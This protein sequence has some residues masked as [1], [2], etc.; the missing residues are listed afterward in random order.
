[1]RTQTFSGGKVFHLARIDDEAV[2]NF[3]VSKIFGDLRGVVHGAAEE[4]DFASVLVGELDSEINAVDRRREA[5]DKKAALGVG[6]DFVELAAD[7]ALAGRVSLALDVGGILKQGQHA[8][9]AVFGEGVQVEKF[10]VG[11]CGI[12]LEIASVNDDA[13]RRVDREGN[14]IDQAMRDLDRMNRE[15]SGLEA[16]VGAH[17]AEVGVVEQAVLVEFV[18]DVSE[19][20]LGAPD[21]DVKFGEHPGE[22]ADVVFVAVSEDDSANA[23]AVFGEIRNVGNDDVDAEEFGF[24]EHESGVDDDD[25]VSPADGHAVHAEFAEAPEGNDLQFSGGH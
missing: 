2:G 22:C 25:V 13:E 21:R 24:G 7:G 10:V 20:E 8:R 15:G 4:G 3:D 11:G 5:R 1:M 9:F 17:F 12:N 14:A 16:L 23:L 18:F 19:R 6:E